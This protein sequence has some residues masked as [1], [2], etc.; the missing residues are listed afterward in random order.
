[1]SIV[2]VVADSLFAAAV[3]HFI[4][5]TSRRISRFRSRYI[6]AEETFQ[7][8]PWVVSQP[9]IRQSST[10]SSAPCTAEEKSAASKP[11]PRQRR[12]SSQSKTP[13]SPWEAEKSKGHSKR[14]ASS[15]AIS[16]NSRDGP[17]RASIGTMNDSAGEVTY[18]PTTHRI[19]KAKKGKKVH[20][21]EFPGCTKV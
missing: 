15:K 10:T 17:S 3:F 20:A 5:H 11:H 19:S 8:I 13:V 7:H 6:M 4:V 9:R 14:S 18:T 1:M 12:S 2:H 21:C 16:F